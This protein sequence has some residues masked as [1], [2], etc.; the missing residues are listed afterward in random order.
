M[1]LLAF[2]Q[3]TTDST[4][5]AILTVGGLFDGYTE[6][7]LWLTLVV[8][9]AEIFTAGF[10]LGALAVSSILT[11][12]GAWLGLPAEWQVGFFALSS[13]G[14]LLW[15]RPVAVNLLSRHEVVTNAAGLVGR[16]GTVVAQVPAGG[17]G[18]VRLVNEEWRATSSQG[19]DVGAAVKVLAVEGNTLTVGPA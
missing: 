6:F 8:M 11:A 18:R 7:W 9:I 4:L 5:H 10:F 1:G 17:V 12:L 16:P 19:L 3:A 2:A 13:I 15:V 14:S